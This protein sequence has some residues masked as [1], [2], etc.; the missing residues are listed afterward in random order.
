MSKRLLLSINEELYK[1][2]NKEAKSNYTNIQEIIHR[3]L[4]KHVK[5]QDAKKDPIYEE[6][7][8]K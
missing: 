6:S 5:K 7:F 8:T 1:K 2:L 4:V 3:I